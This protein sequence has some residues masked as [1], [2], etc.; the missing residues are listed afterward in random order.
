MCLNF[1]AQMK[2][3]ESGGTDSG[4]Q[5]KGGLEFGQRRRKS[6]SIAA[7]IPWRFSRAECR[8][9]TSATAAAMVRVG[10]VKGC[11]Q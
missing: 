6:S 1:S 11:G 7:M 4:E 8:L 3:L 9:A 5:R 10:K 2:N